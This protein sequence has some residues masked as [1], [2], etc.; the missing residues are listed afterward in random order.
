[1]VNRESNW[2]KIVSTRKCKRVAKKL[3][4][5]GYGVWK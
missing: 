3:D 4:V 5:T 2:K 1:M